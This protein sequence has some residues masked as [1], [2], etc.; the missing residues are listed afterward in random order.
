MEETLTGMKG[1]DPELNELRENVLI[2][3]QVSVSY[4][5]LQIKLINSLTRSH[6]SFILITS[7]HTPFSDE[8]MYHITY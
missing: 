2:I 4:P 1:N 6:V 8:C 5:W 7:E 3:V